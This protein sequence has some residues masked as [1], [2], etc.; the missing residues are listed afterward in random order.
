MGRVLSSS[1]SATVMPSR[2]CLVESSSCP[3][4]WLTPSGHTNIAWRAHVYSDCAWSLCSG[5]SPSGRSHR[6]HREQR[7]FVLA[8]LRICR[9]TQVRIVASKFMRSSELR[10]SFLGWPIDMNRFLLL[11]GNSDS[12]VLLLKNA[13][14][15][16]A[17]AVGT[18]KRPRAADLALAASET[19]GGRNSQHGLRMRGGRG[20]DANAVFIR[21]ALG[22]PGSMLLP[23]CESSI[24]YRMR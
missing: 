6:P 4:V 18:G 2:S 21:L 9:K 17:R 13:L 11:F 24:A 22:D 3:E 23:K 16:P 15:R 19:A 5:A 20:K 1:D 14:C 12:P 8:R 10:R 7:P